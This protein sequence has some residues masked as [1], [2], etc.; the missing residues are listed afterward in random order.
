MY[1]G[2]AEAGRGAVETACTTGGDDAC[3]E[4]GVCKVE[5]EGAEGETGYRNGG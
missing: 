5:D 2:G 4:L 3:D 1:P